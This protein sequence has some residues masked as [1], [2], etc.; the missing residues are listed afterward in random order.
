V[1]NCKAPTFCALAIF[2]TAFHA[3]DFI[4]SVRNAARVHGVKA[5]NDNEIGNSLLHHFFIGLKWRGIA[6]EAEDGVRSPRRLLGRPG[7]RN[8]ENREHE[9]FHLVVRKGAGEVDHV[10][11]TMMMAI[12]VFN[13]DK[14]ISS[15]A[16]KFAELP[17]HL[18]L[19]CNCGRLHSS[20]KGTHY[21]SGLAEDRRCKLMIS[22]VQRMVEAAPESAL[23]AD[24][25]GSKMYPFMMAAVAEEGSCKNLRCLSPIYFLLQ[26]FLAAND[27]TI[28]LSQGPQTAEKNN[29]NGNYCERVAGRSDD[30]GDGCI[31]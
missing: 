17:L 25:K 6:Q 20:I 4:R 15:V 1:D 23:K 11:K 27:L 7:Q 30:D 3:R 26:R 18:A 13:N 19:Q 2:A 14:I 22:V 24:P 10:W 8:L 5:N 16:N 31:L 29:E 28:F 21:A 12:I 9:T